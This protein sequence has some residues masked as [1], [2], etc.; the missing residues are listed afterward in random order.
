MAGGKSRRLGRDKAE[1]LYKN[2]PLLDHAIDLL[3]ACHLNKTIILGRAHPLGIADPLP[4]AGPAANLKS[5]INAQ[6][7]PV[8]LTVIPVDMPLLRLVQINALRTTPTGGYFDDLYLPFAATVTHPVVGTI[9]RMK[10]LLSALALPK[11]SV[12]PH[13]QNALGNFNTAEDFQRLTK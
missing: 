7:H 4:D 13:W 3:S 6:P 12:P 11:V 2:K 9:L 10:D 5:W 8:H 1:L